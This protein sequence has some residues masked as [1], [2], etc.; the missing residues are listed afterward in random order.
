MINETDMQTIINADL[1]GD[2]DDENLSWITPSPLAS[3]S[4]EKAKSIKFKNLVIFRAEIARNR[5][6]QIDRLISD[7]QS[8]INKM[9]QAE[10][11]R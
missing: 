8:V 7:Y 4:R 2:G 5:M 10:A 1:A 3:I 11:A 6:G 9:G